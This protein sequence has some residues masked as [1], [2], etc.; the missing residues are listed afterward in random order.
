MKSRMI[1]LPITLVLLA[2]LASLVPLRSLADQLD[3]VVTPASGVDFCRAAQPCDGYDCGSQVVTR[4]ACPGSLYPGDGHCWAGCSPTAAAV[5]LNYWDQNG[6]PGLTDSMVQAIVDLHD[7][8]GTHPCGGTSPISN[9]INGIETYASSRGFAFDAELVWYPS[10]DDLRQEID[11]RR[12]VFVSNGGHSF[13]CKGYDTNDQKLLLDMNY[14]DP[15]DP[16]RGANVLKTYSDSGIVRAIVIRPPAPTPTPTPTP[17]PVPPIGDFNGDE[18]EDIVT[19]IGDSSGDVWVALNNGGTGF[20]TANKWHDW[21]APDNEIPGAGDFNNDGYDDIVTFVSDGS[22]DVFVALNSGGTGFGIGHKWHDW[23]AP[24]DEIPGVGDFDNDGYDDIVTFTS[25]AN[26]NVYVALN[27]GGTGFGTGHKW[28]D[29]FA[30][31]DEIPGVGNF[32]KDGYDD[33]VTFTNDSDDRVWVALNNRGTGFGT[34]SLW[35]PMASTPT[36]T[37][38]PTQTPTCTPTPTTT[39]KVYLPVVIKN[40]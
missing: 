11:A 32:N 2:I 35:Y 23:F 12:P 4:N 25:D 6:Y 36:P 15:N 13:V 19:S 22:G 40:Q 1:H 8:M 38:T 16:E 17:I 37:N 34:S 27:N 10:F 39:T 28:H 30:P 33:I 20:S 24:N 7:D 18:Y 26:G 9:Q 29:W 3:L 5:I 21:F 31:N 14:G